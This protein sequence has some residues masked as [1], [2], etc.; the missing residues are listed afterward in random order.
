MALGVGVPL[1]HHDQSAAASGGKPAG[2][3]QVV[4][5]AGRVDGRSE[6][7]K[8]ILQSKIRRGLVGVEIVTRRDDLLVQLGEVRLGVHVRAVAGAVH[9][10]PARGPI[11][12]PFEGPHHAVG[13]ARVEPRLPGVH[14]ISVA[15][16]H[17]SAASAQ[18]HPLYPTRRGRP[19]WRSAPIINLERTRYRGSAPWIAVAAATAFFLRA[20]PICHLDRRRKAVAA[21]TAVQSAFGTARTIAGGDARATNAAWKLHANA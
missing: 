18:N 11:E 7:Q 17:Q 10:R 9:A 5:G 3:R 12:S 21:A 13:V 6:K 2:P 1:R 14:P 20:S 4:A 16:P 8:I 15:V 19:L